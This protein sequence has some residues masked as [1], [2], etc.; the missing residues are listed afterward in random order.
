MSSKFK[1]FGN[2][3]VAL[4]LGLVALSIA[5]LMG[6]LYIS[7]YNTAN[8]LEQGIMATHKNNEILLANYGQKV[9]E[10]VQV[11]EMARDD[12]QILIR[13]AL[14]GRYGSDGSK[15]VFQAISEQNP[16]VDPGLYRQIQQIIESGRNDF[17][18][19]QTRLIDQKR[20]YDTS[21]NSFITGAFMRMAG[22]PKIQLNDYQPVTTTRAASIFKEGV[23]EPIQLRPRAK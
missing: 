17:Q 7:S 3:T 1:S 19:G 15:S 21:R 23:E 6:V 10:A 9:T 8:A 2:A 12:I 14:V 4:V 16:S 22:Y 11:P 5:A 13:E 20:V 18:Q